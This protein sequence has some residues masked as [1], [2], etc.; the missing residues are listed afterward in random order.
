M[1]GI[2]DDAIRSFILSDIDTLF[3]EKFVIKKSD[4][5]I[6]TLV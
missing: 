2:P 5:P 4:I 1:V 6:T 3:L